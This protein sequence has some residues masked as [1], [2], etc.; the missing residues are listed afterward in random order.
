M[1]LCSNTFKKQL[2]ELFSSFC[3]VVFQSSFGWG[4]AQG[5]CEVGRLLGRAELEP[6][7]S[8]GI[9][10]R[11]CGHRGLGVILSALPGH[12]SDVHVSCTAQ[13][14]VTAQALTC[15]QHS[16]AH[17]TALGTAGHICTHLQSTPA[18]CPTEVSHCPQRNHSTDC[19][20]CPCP[21]GSGGTHFSPS[22]CSTRVTAAGLPSDPARLC[23]CSCASAPAEK[24]Q[25]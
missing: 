5:T 9:P 16:P 21:K 13:G 23:C 17:S 19:R 8:R 12:Q 24:K 1:L 6:A 4:G 14:G 2:W 11:P 20:C 3:A 15:K 10:A 18:E 25:L 7:W 22:L